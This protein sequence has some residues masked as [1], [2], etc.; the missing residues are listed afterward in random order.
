MRRCATSSEAGS[1]EPIP[2]ALRKAGGYAWRLL[3]LVVTL[4]VVLYALRRLALVML[5][6]VV[7]LF[8][9]A[10]L[11]PPAGWLRRRG[12]P[13]WAATALTL[14][15]ALALSVG[16]GALVL[17]GVIDQF[18]ALDVSLQQSLQ[19][20]ERYLA[21][22]LPLSQAD[23][24][25]AVSD[26]VNTLKAEVRDLRMGFFGIARF[27][28][29]VIVGAFISVFAVFFFLKDGRGF[30]A[31]FCG[32]FPEQRQE[33]VRQ[34]GD[35]SWTVLKRYLQGVAFVAV[36][37]SLLIAIAL[38]LIGVPLVLPLAAITFFAAFFPLV[39]AITAGL[40]A[41]LVAFV[42]GGPIDALLV[43]GAIVLVQQIEGNLL[44]PLIV[45]RQVR[46]H[47]LAILLAV[48]A[49]G[50]LAGILGAFLAVP[51][52]AVIVTVVDYLRSEE[53]NPEVEGVSPP[54][55]LPRAEVVPEEPAPGSAATR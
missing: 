13:S 9:T 16:V 15:G 21:G 40:L 2:L 18:S 52:T 14:S 54:D 30:F 10:V 6:V 36:V 38:V 27:V 7:A 51:V 45:G 48:T 37:D 43:I 47:P 19:R 3:L 26:A 39:G 32:L 5:P 35:R 11:D 33:R 25:V 20:I 44:Y 49:G 12:L 8:V 4:A 24:R 42:S 29:E 22:L 31:G 41:A 17:P 46:L 28:V 23:L 55:G 50:L 34:I 53:P 1:G